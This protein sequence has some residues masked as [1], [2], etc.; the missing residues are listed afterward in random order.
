V[1]L[2]PLVFPN[3]AYLYAAKKM[4]PWLNC[5]PLVLAAAGGLEHST[6]GSL[7][8]CFTTAMAAVGPPIS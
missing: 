4:M 3:L 6:L 7:E 8:E 5:K 2:P 1:I